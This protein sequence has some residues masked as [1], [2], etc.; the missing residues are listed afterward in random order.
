MH[1]YKRVF[2]QHSQKKNFGGKID[3]RAVM[4][5]P[6]IQQCQAFQRKIFTFFWIE[7]PKKRTKLVFTK[8]AIL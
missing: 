3:H 4:L 6:S 2:L 5:H 8:P 1:S 7:R